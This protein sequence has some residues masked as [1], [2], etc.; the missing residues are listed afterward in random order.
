MKQKRVQN[1]KRIFTVAGILI[2]LTAITALT[3]AAVTDD[4][5]IYTNASVGI[6]TA[7]PNTDQGAGKEEQGIGAYEPAV[8]GQGIPD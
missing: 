4:G 7:D 6:G 2:M 1:K 8:R 5:R 3:A